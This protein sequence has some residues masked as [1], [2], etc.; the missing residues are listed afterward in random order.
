MQLMPNTA[1]AHGVTNANDPEQ[2]LNAGKK[3]LS[4][5]N[6]FWKERIEN[7]EERI[8]FVLASYN[9][10]QGHVEDAIALA[11]K[12]GHS[13]REWEEVEEFLLKKSMPE[14]YLDPVVKYGYCRGIETKNYIQTIYSIYN[15]Y[16]E[17]V[18]EIG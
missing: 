3:H 5:L 8:K 4:W 1:R 11:K 7:P 16:Q 2:N 9:I 18:P 13:G 17:L 12:N 15:T 6:E 10:G 14:F